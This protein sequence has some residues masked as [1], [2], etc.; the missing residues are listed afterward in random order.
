LVEPAD[1]EVEPHPLD[2]PGGAGGLDALRP[3]ENLAVR[4]QDGVKL[5]HVGHD[6]AADGQPLLPLRPQDLRVL[7]LQRLLVGVAGRA[8]PQQKK[9]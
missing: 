1:D 4:R 8:R 6:P 7:F 2:L 9:Y 5:E 3:A